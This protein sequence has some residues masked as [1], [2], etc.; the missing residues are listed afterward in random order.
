MFYAEIKL[1]SFLGH[2][3]RAVDTELPLAVV[4]LFIQT[5]TSISTC[6]C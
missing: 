2:Y 3:E 1:F 4:I 5:F 6:L